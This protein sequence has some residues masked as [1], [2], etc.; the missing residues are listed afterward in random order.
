[1][2]QASYYKSLFKNFKT[3][4]LFF[5]STLRLK[6]TLM[7]S[8]G[9]CACRK[10]PQFP[11]ITQVLCGSVNPFVTDLTLSLEIAHLRSGTSWE[12]EWKCG[13]LKPL[14]ITAIE[15]LYTDSWVCDNTPRARNQSLVMSYNTS[16]WNLHYCS[17]I[18][19]KP[20]KSSC[21]R[22]KLWESWIESNAE[23][24]IL[25]KQSP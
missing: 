19:L 25:Y 20:S 24:H 4:E 1:M 5:E 18:Y 8:N 11:Q 22:A 6:P 3:L 12:N 15:I 16:I 17:K 14:S 13:C 9:S 10:G 23:Y 21:K 2:E 7:A